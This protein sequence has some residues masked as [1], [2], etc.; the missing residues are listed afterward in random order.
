[1]RYLI[2]VSA[3]NDP[4]VFLKLTQ[5]RMSVISQESWKNLDFRFF[6]K[7]L[8]VCTTKTSR[9]CGCVS[10]VIL[11]S[12]I[13]WCI[14]FLLISSF[15]VTEIT[16]LFRDIRFYRC[17]RCFSWGK[18]PF[19]PPDFS[20][21][22]LLSIC[23]CFLVKRHHIPVPSVSLDFLQLGNLCCSFPK[24]SANQ[25]LFCLAVGPDTL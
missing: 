15:L 5:C 12:C 2:V 9:I 22:F 18:M 23:S 4:V 20:V 16:N 21:D 19:F 13:V 1:M 14:Y 25:D 17:F 24:C 11:E 3:Q 6:D 7:Q 8:R 10:E